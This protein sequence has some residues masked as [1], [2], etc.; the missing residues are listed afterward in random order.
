[1]TT[2]YDYAQEGRAR[3]RDEKRARAHY[4]TML[5]DA[6]AHEL[7]YWGAP[8]HTTPRVVNI[9]R[10]AAVWVN[11]AAVTGHCRYRDADG[12]YYWRSAGA[13]GTLE[14]ARTIAASNPAAW[15]YLLAVDVRTREEWI[16]PT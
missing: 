13:S 2:T 11:G 9:Y 14:E 16:V 5:A 4:L 10:L 12:R 7:G 6:R 8:Q 1:M 15:R 3:R